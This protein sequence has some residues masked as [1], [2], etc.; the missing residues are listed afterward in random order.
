MTGKAKYEPLNDM[1]CN[2]KTIPVH[3]ELVEYST[4]I[5]W[6]LDIRRIFKITWKIPHIK[7]VEAQIRVQHVNCIDSQPFS[8]I[9]SH[10]L[11]PEGL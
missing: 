7:S 10:N 9:L 1:S 4:E 3:R 6:I 8:A 11:P 5:S 2:Y